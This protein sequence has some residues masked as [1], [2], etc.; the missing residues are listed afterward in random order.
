MQQLNLDD[1]AWM[2]ILD[3][4]REAENQRLWASGRPPRVPGW[5]K[6][7]LAWLVAA[8]RRQGRRPRAARPIPVRAVADQRTAC[9]VCRRRFRAL[10]NRRMDGN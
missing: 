8:M 4:Q 5:L 9:E 3:L 2:R 1:V 7:I 6:R 10:I